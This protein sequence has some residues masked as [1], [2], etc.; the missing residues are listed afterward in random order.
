ML[1]GVDTSDSE[2]SDVRGVEVFEVE[3]VDSDE[4]DCSVKEN[5]KVCVDSSVVEV[6]RIV[7]IGL[8]VA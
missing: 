2:L 5:P 7:S 6:V 4:S 8:F 3:R 1:A